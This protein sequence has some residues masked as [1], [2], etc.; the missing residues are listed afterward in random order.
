MAAPDPRRELERR[1]EEEKPAREDVE[2]RH[3]RI[4]AESAVE[5]IDLRRALRRQG[6]L[7]VEGGEDL[8]PRRLGAPGEVAGEGAAPDDRGEADR[9]EQRDSDPQGANDRGGRQA[10]DG[11]TD[12]AVHP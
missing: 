6:I 2:H 10:E 8:L 3:Q 7:P 11:L 1:E 12:G 5:A 9:D 4:V